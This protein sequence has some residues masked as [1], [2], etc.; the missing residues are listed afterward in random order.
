MYRH[1]PEQDNRA[2]ILGLVAAGTTALVAFFVAGRFHNLNG[3]LRREVKSRREAQKQT[4]ER[5][6]QLHT[7]MANLPGMAYRCDFRQDWHMR[8]VSEGC[9]ELT[10]Y[11]RYRF[12]GHDG[13]NFADIIHPQDRAMV[14]DE[15]L[16][17]AGEDR[18]C[19]LSYRVIHADNTVKWVWEQARVFENI[20]TGEEF[21][22]GFITDITALKLAEQERERLITEL[23]NALGEIRTLK[24]ILPICSS[25]KKIRDDQGYWNQIEA[26]IREHS[27]A[28]F[29]HGIC[30]DC[31]RALYPDFVDQEDFPPEKAERE[32][33]NP[34]EPPPPENK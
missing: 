13:M 4:L 19:T 25:C 10:G 14:W 8:F 16:S 22:E 17:A 5:E 9:K 20:E 15:V 18:S 7:L 28:Q 26:Y 33:P 30:P 32:P 29:S 27:Y 21:V 12:L 3:K 1:G 2:L 23:R 6:R 24:G 34:G 31:A 11:E